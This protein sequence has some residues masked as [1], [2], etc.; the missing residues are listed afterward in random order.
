MTESTE[1]ARR[2]RD[3]ADDAEF[4]SQCEA[5]MRDGGDV[6]AL[7]VV[8]PKASPLCREPTPPVRYIF[9]PTILFHSVLTAFRYDVSR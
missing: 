2:V 7:D 1:C 5:G 8:A 3:A 6:V 4:V 9:L